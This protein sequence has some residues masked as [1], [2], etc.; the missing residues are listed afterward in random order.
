MKV[1]LALLETAVVRHTRWIFAGFALVAVAAGAA[2]L[3]VEI[4]SSAEQMLI[5]GDPERVLNRERKLEFSNDEVMVVAFDLGH[6]FTA[7]DLRK[8]RS[9]S[10]GVAAIEGVEEIIDLSNVE[11]VRD[12]DGSL[13]ASNLVE[14]DE[15]GSSAAAVRA[16]ALGHRL[17]DQNLLS[18]DFTVL[19]MVV[20]FELGENYEISK[21]RAI[22]DTLDLLER[23]A[24]PWGVNVAGYP[25][26]EYESTQVLQRD[27]TILTTVALLG[28]LGVMYWTTRRWFPLMLLGVLIGWAQVVTTGWFGLTGTP[29]SI[30]TSLVPAI[31]VALASTYAIYFVWLLPQVSDDPQPGR[32]IL[33]CIARPSLLSAVSTGVGFLSLRALAMEQIGQLGTALTVAIASAVVGTLLLLPALVNRFGLKLEGMRL[34]SFDAWSTLGTRL[35]Q[36][37]LL[38]IGVAAGLVALAIPGIPRIAFDTDVVDNFRKGTSRREQVAFIREHLA[39]T[40]LLNIVVRAKGGAGSALEPETLAFTEAMI[41]KLEAHRIVDRTISLLDYLA[42]I[43]TALRPGEEPRAVPPTRELAAQ[44]LLLYDS[45]G[46]PGDYRHYVNFDRSSLNVFVR[47]NTRSSAQILALKREIDAIAATAPASVDVDVLGSIY[48]WAKASDQLT[49]GVV[50]GLSIAM[51]LIAA[52]M[53]LSLRS[54]KL[55][56]VG[57]IP[58]VLPILLCGG[59]LGWFGGS[60]S[61]GISIVGC[62]A[63]GLAV[64]DT[65]HILGHLRRDRSLEAT[66][67]IVGRP[68]ILTTVSLALGFATLALSAFRPVA[69]LGVA[70]SI[71]LVAALAFDLLVLPSLLVLAGYRARDPQAQP[72]ARPHEAVGVPALG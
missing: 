40:V 35:A 7:D 32:A 62:V 57:A 17:Y 60:L 6:A 8:L 30:V 5:R 53:A 38:T 55:A 28:I 59:L 70:T 9:L 10:E 52:V 34:P 19:S 43:D 25:V 69:V 23:E 21:S 36:R 64:D 47:M 14:F 65:A 67:R 41:Q 42:L 63:L 4:N 26:V 18:D 15:L 16:R 20:F 46:D 27:L 33:G 66:Y 68:V 3:R 54:L 39:G 49:R 12:S 37:P 24:R 44:Y 58:N 72:E 50:Q 31:T 22:A 29:I 71:T 56:L 48:L 11:D 1:L 45:S 13:D 2:A 61:I 51:L